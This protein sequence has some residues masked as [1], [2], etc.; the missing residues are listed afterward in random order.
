MTSAAFTHDES[1][2]RHPRE[3]SPWVAALVAFAIYSCTLG[4][5]YVYDDIEVIRND[6]RIANPSLWGQYFTQQYMLGRSD[7]LF[8]PLVSLSFAIQWW[9]HGDRPWLFHLAN[10]LLH[11]GAAAAVAFL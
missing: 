1:E 7:K 3:W 6:P 4:G 8:R 5:T 2:R 10:L 9:L 11:A